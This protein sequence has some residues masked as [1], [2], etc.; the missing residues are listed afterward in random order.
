MKRAIVTGANGF[1][2]SY[3]IQELLCHDYEVLAVVHTEHGAEKIRALGESNIHTAVCDIP[4][5]ENLY[6]EACGTY[7][8]F[9]HMAWTGVSGPQNRN[10]SIQM[11]NFEGAVRAVEAARDLKCKRFLGAGSIH[12]IECMKEMESSDAVSNYA[13]FYKASKLAAHYYCKLKAAQYGIDFL[14]PRLTN[15]YGVGERSE[16][17]ISSVIQQLLRGESP[18]LTEGKQMYN[19]I[20]ITDAAVAYRLIGEKGNAFHEYVLG[21]NEVRPLRD[22]LMKVGEIVNS[23]VKLGFGE[24]LFHGICLTEDA[25]ISKELFDD[26]G[27]SPAV[28]FDEGIQMTADWLRKQ[29]SNLFEG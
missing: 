28:A 15:T 24:H 27:F 29:I 25:L 9:F 17:L 21:S 16:R 1:I 20:Y 4:D 18:A 22:Y 13:N 12:E 2:G 23:H 10:G 7:D 3:L 8:I 19:F 11:N 14:W 6:K 26:I 5:F